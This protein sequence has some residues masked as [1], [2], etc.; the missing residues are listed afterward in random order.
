MKDIQKRVDDDTRQTKRRKV[1][2]LPEDYDILVAYGKA[3]YLSDETT[4][5]RECSSS[6]HEFAGSSRAKNEFGRDI[7]RKFVEYNTIRER[8]TNEP[9]HPL[10]S[11]IKIFLSLTG[12][13]SGELANLQPM[14]A[15]FPRELGANL[16]RTLYPQSRMILILCLR[17]LCQMRS[18]L[19]N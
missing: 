19:G 1:Y 9:K 14:I 2:R 11:M 12:A 5:K 15:I 7:V 17:T 6:S 4:I 8:N 10:S 3:V 16:V 18:I 13:K